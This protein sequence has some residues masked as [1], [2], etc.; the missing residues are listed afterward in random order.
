MRGATRRGRLSSRE[1]TPGVQ[2]LGQ[3]DRGGEVVTSRANRQRTRADANEPRWLASRSA[4]PPTDSFKIFARFDFGNWLYPHDCLASF[5]EKVR[6]LRFVTM[7][8]IRHAAMQGRSDARHDRGRSR[9]GSP[10]SQRKARS[11]RRRLLR[12]CNLKMAISHCRSEHRRN[13]CG[14]RRPPVAAATLPRVSIRQQQHQ[15]LQQERTFQQAQ[16]LQVANDHS[17]P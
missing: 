11:R 13:R 5:V 8:A 12:T 16:S 14:C 6:D 2:M 10:L 1:S 7:R 17:Q 15:R 3:A 4:G 9:A